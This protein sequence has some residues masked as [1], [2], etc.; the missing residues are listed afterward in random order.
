M[1]LTRQ[2]FNR[3]RDFILANA[4]MIERRLFDF[5]FNG[6]STNGVFH[7]VYAYR[8]NDGGFGYGMEPDTASPKS[9]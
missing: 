4:R 8:N 2:N 6:G 7:S 1:K 9:K 3:A 5:H